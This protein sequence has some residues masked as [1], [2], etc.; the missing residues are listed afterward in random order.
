MNSFTA[1]PISAGGASEISPARQRWDQNQT[2]SQAPEVRQILPPRH[3]AN[4]SRQPG[5]IRFRLPPITSW[6]L[7]SH[8]A[9][10]TNVWQFTVAIARTLPYKLSNLFLFSH[11]AAGIARHR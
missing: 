2:N 9:N 3:A 4:K 6:A 10:Q 1:P 8:Y 7:P 5:C 11:L